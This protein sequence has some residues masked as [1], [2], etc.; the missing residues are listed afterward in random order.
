MILGHEPRAVML[1]AL[2]SGILLGLSA[3]LAP[4]P[5]LALVLAQT[6][7]HGPREGCKVALTPL[8]TDPPIILATLL[9]AT[10]L[11]EL[12]PLLGLI[13][14]AGAI[15]V[16]CLAWESFR[17]VLRDPAVPL[18]RPRSWFKGIVTNL[19]NP[20][21]WIFWLTVGAAMLAG[22]MARGWPAVVVF[23]VGFYVLLVG[24]KV[25]LALLTGRSRDWLA[26]G[27]Y[28]VVMR[29][30]A[31]LLAGFALLLFREGWRQLAGG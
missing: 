15:F 31:V 12:R 14:I 26:G 9:L 21:P 11:A 4:G 8:V 16:L 30:L 19:L 6:L 27:S 5:M 3:G 23:L 22:S 29:V 20:H 18:E 10:R 13:S 28:R 24:S 25:L 7:R 1:T 17:P 2:V